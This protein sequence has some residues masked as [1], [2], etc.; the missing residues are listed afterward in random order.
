[1]RHNCPYELL[2]R[3]Y[4]FGH[5]F[6]WTPLR[7]EFIVPVAHRREPASTAVSTL[8]L[9]RYMI[10]KYFPNIF[11]GDPCFTFFH[12]VMWNTTILNIIA[13]QIIYFF[14]VH[15]FGVI[16]KNPL[17]NL[18]S[19]RFIFIVPSKNFTVLAFALRFDPFWINFCVGYELRV[20]LHFFLHMIIQLSQHHWLKR[21][22]FSI[23]CSWHSCE[24]SVGPTQM[25]S[26]LDSWFYSSDLYVTLS[27]GPDYHCFLVSSRIRN[28]EF[29][30]FAFIFK[31]VLAIL[32][33]LQFHVNARIS[34]SIST[35]K[36]DGILIR[37]MLNL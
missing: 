34:L 16:S 14:V 3:R 31:I 13:F 19:Q 1:M 11:S 6:M 17:Q 32:G 20:P 4:C 26:F 36:S 22:F 24:K 9:M 15:A 30:Y 7:T 23:K 35:T 12:G 28:Y 5:R 21:I 2:C 27:Y 37:I 8:P 25:V 10:C 18:R 33:N 29:S